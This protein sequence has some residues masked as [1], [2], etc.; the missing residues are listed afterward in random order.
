[1]VAMSDGASSDPFGAENDPAFANVPRFLWDY[2]YDHSDL[3][4]AAE[5]LRKFLDELANEASIPVHTIESRAKRLTS[6]RDKALKRKPDG[7]LKYTSPA[8]EI[9]DCIAARVILYTSRARDDFADVIEKRTTV[10]E[11]QN[12][13]Q[14]KHNGYDSEHFIVTGLRD[15][16]SRGRYTA[17]A[18]FLDKYPGLEIQLRSVAAHAWAEYEHDVRYKSG[19]YNELSTDAKSQIDQW[20]VEAGGMRRVMD[21]LFD[22]IQE[23]LYASPADITAP[24]DPEEMVQDLEDDPGSD[25][26]M[27]ALDAGSLSE[28]IADRYPDRRLGD[29]QALIP[30]L[31][32]LSALQVT[33]IPQLESSLS[34][35]ELGEVARLMDYPIGPT[36]V[37][38]LDDELLAVF[39]DRYIEV[40]TDDDRR[41][42]LGLRLRRVRGKFAIYSI[43]NGEIVR[44][45]VAAARAVRDLAGLVARR[46]GIDAA[47]VAEAI[48][49]SR[50][51]LRPS[52]KPRAVRT[53]NGTL[54]VATNFTRSWAESVMRKLVSNAPGS[55]LRVIRAGDVLCEAPLDEA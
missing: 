35:V 33:T 48:A 32:Q 40:D 14:T 37:R 51:D 29:A 4:D 41:Q 50:E 54:F 15:P 22:Q 31:T 38:L 27:R 3:A 46:S 6:Y 9:R 53:A 55:G 12:P 17:L 19:A 24:I 2:A 10:V 11:R 26:E 5:D 21:D 28:Y 45:P 7:S 8:H 16:G 49:K 52:A 42:L 30:L 20:F 39:T 44:R 34:T 36:G 25:P 47:I 43:D 23:R 13:G 18:S 1:M